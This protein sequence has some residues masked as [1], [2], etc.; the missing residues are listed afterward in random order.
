MAYFILC[1]HTHALCQ[2]RK[3]SCVLSQAEL[4]LTPDQISRARDVWST[5]CRQAQQIWDRRRAAIEVVSDSK[6]A[7]APTQGVLSGPTG[8]AAGFVQVRSCIT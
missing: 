7:L 1:P 3:C 5:Y 8:I 4:D 2:R 6:S